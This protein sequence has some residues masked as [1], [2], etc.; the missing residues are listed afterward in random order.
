MKTEPK[1]PCKDCKKK[2]NCPRVC[3]PWKDYMKR[4]RRR[5]NNG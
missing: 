3:Y 4:Y 5:S 1:S 2:P